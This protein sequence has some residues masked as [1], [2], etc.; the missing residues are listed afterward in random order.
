MAV[1]FRE[2]LIH[3][4]HS[5]KTAL[6]KEP[7]Q[8][9]HTGRKNAQGKTNPFASFNICNAKIEMLTESKGMLTTK[10]PVRKAPSTELFSIN[11]HQ[12][13]LF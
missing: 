4:I 7:L 8:T 3:P 1:K 13:L 11:S 10:L 5:N 9:E 12:E 2:V 6:F